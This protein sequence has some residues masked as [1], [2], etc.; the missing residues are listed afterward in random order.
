MDYVCIH[1]WW[2][3]KSKSVFSPW[4]PKLSGI[5]LLGLTGEQ[6]RCLMGEKRAAAIICYCVFV[7]RYLYCESLVAARVTPLMYSITS[8][9]CHFHFSTECKCREKSNFPHRNMYFVLLPFR[10]SFFLH[11]ICC[12]AQS[13]FFLSTKYWRSELPE[14]NKQ[15]VCSVCRLSFRQASYKLSLFLYVL[16]LKERKMRILYEKAECKWLYCGL[17]EVKR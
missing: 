17:S 16:T 12:S 11:F 6:K 14:T 7:S 1:L 8:N 3:S 9:S 5:S 2:L 15:A 13:I 10:I 4:V